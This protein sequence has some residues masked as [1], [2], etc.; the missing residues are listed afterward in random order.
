[1]GRLRAHRFAVQRR[2]SPGW[3][4]ATQ[5]CRDC[6]LVLERSDLCNWEGRP[7]KGRARRERN[8]VH[9]RRPR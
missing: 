6:G 1:M 7:C 8:R 2:E 4:S 3:K 9:N 5:R